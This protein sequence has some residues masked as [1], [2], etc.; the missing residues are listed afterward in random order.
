MSTPHGFIEKLAELSKGGGPFVA[1][2]MV[3]AVGSTPQDAGTKM[4]VD[5]T[6]L[7]FGTVGGGR[8][9]NQALE[10][11]QRML[12]EKDSPSTRLVDWNLQRDVGMTCG[13]EVKLYFEA[14]N[15]RTWR[16]VVFGAGHVAQ[17]LV[18]C[19]VDL[20]CQVVC[21]DPRQDWLIR[22]PQSGKLHRVQLENMPEY[23][24]QLTDDD[25]VV[26]MTMGHRTDRPI[27]EEIF[28]QGRRP[29]YLGVIGS[30]A[31]RK[32][33]IRELTESGIGHETAEAFRCPIG[34][35]LG[36]NQPG[37]IAVSIAAELI[38]VRDALGAKTHA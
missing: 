13:G 25:F 10:F 15:H 26:C 19:L 31:K 11:A 6:G 4:L 27:L 30:E 29:A 16:I 7:V 12:R 37:E 38:Q 24:P 17:A 20:E 33:M 23:V 14:Y 2:T 22:L 8:I 18:R 36:T 3:D 34:L 5:A 28:R 1:V 9:E 32:V 21:V 35:R